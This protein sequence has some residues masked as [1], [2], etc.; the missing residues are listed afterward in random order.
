MCPVYYI[1]QFLNQQP[2]CEIKYAY[3]TYLHILTCL[4]TTKILKV[5]IL[6]IKI[7]YITF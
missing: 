4:I 2:V 7:I 5:L 3:L 1:M 6:K